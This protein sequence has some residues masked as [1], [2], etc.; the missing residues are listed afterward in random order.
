MKRDIVVVGASAGGVEATTL[1][2]QGMDRAFQGSAFF[3]LH[4]M[5]YTHSY[6]PHLLSRASGGAAAH[7]GNGEPIRPRR[8]Y[9]A[10]PDHHMVLDPASI[11]LTRDPEHNRHR[12]SIDVLFHSAA[13]AFGPRVTGVLL[14]GADDDGASGLL[15]IRREGGVTIVQDPEEA[16]FPQ[17]PRSAMDRFDPDYILPAAEIGRRLVQL[18]RE[19]VKP[20]RER[21]DAQPPSVEQA[22]FSCPDCGGP[23]TE[24]R[25]GNTAEYRC[26]I[27]HSYTADGLVRAGAETVERALWAAVRML[28]DGAT[29]SRRVASLMEESSPNRAVYEERAKAKEDHARIIR[30]MMRDAAAK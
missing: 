5:P 26:I 12:P 7:P 8:I 23:L 14:S 4:L 18:V 17:M 9:A 13:Q 27:G 2:A 22:P 24:T 15:H 11:R 1:V 21:R 29:V 25:R 6:F 3:V 16:A 10:P 20:E 19:D 30:S 28:E